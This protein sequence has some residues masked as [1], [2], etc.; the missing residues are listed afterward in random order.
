MLDVVC[1]VK[2]Q[3]LHKVSSMLHPR[4]ALDRR[5][6]MIRQVQPEGHDGLTEGSRWACH[7]ALRKEQLALWLVSQV[8]RLPSYGYSSTDF[9]VRAG[10][11]CWESRQQD[12][13]QSDRQCKMRADGST[14][15]LRLLFL[16]SRTTTRSLLALATLFLICGTS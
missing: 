6:D 11:C 7:T 5:A 8:L 3:L 16:S 9:R 4:H 15:L 13:V 1:R 10:D 12:K 2:Q 14:L